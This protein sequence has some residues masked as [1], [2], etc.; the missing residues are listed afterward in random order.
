L[1]ALV[2]KI[3]RP[4]QKIERLHHNISAPKQESEEVSVADFIDNTSKYKG[5]SM[6]FEM[7]L[8]TSGDSLRQHSGGRAEF[9]LLGDNA[10]AQVEIEIP[11]NLDLPN[12]SDND[13]LIV[14]FK[15]TEGRLNSGNIAIGIQRR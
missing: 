12:A 10:S 6:Q 9:Y 3:L 7:S 5:D 4:L 1:C 14:T 8:N 11:A 13:N 2:G 15:C